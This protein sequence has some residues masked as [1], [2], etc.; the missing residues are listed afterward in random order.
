[1]NVTASSTDSAAQAQGHAAQDAV[2]ALCTYLIK[3]TIPF[4]EV[5]CRNS[6]TFLTWSG[7]LDPN[8]F[9]ERVTDCVHHIY[10]IFNANKKKRGFERQSNFS[11]SYEDVY[12]FFEG[13]VSLAIPK[14]SIRHIVSESLP[15]IPTHLDTDVAFMIANQLLEM[16]GWIF[17]CRYCGKRFTR[18]SNRTRHEK[19]HVNNGDELPCMLGDCDETFTDLTEFLYHQNVVHDDD[20]DSQNESFNS[21]RSENEEIISSS[22]NSNRNPPPRE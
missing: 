21:R 15:R 9:Q 16:M 17:V 12:V 7:R 1:M 2:S 19:I 22:I 4:S 14:E 11:V 18:D 8:E 5:G 20:S 3:L 10:V 13:F 6:P